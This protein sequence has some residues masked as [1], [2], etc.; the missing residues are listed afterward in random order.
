M[1]AIEC[2]LF[3]KEPPQA[4]NGSM[5]ELSAS[6]SASIASEPMESASIASTSSFTS[7]II[8]EH[9]VKKKTCTESIGNKV[10]SSISTFFS[11]IGSFVSNNPKLTIILALLITA[12]CSIPGLMKLSPEFRPEKLWLPQNTQAEYEEARFLSYFPPTSR[13]QHVV[14]SNNVGAADNGG[15]NALTKDNLITA[16]KMHQQIQNDVS[17]Y[18][19]VDYTFPDLCTSAG[20]SCTSFFDTNP[21]C[22]CLVLSI[23]KVWSYDLE[24]LEND[25]DFMATLNTYGSK[26]EDYESVLGLPV[27]DSNGAL[28]GAEAFT[29]SYF[30]EDRSYV[31]NGIKK[32]P[33][34][35]EWEK[36][37]F[38]TNVQATQEEN[39]EIDF[40]YFSARSFDDEFGGEIEG[41]LIYGG[42]NV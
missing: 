21:V 38:L 4:D 39:E 41:D 23:L 7:N 28:V 35:M 42:L 32:D 22:S 18:D 5:D 37:V 36:T 9:P 16:M 3:A 14:V 27:F 1:P 10:D 2:V 13:L 40:V 26:E 34:N 25:D 29:L 12:G 31:E 19:G 33:I 8:E 20:G 24:R 6:A 15:G 11:H 17:T 30:L